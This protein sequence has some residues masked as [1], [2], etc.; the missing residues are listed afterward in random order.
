VLISRAG[1]PEGGG[2]VW[3]LVETVRGSGG[4]FAGGVRRGRVSWVGEQAS[5]GAF[6]GSSITHKL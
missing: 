5:S 3:Q 1:V 2:K 4:V 6:H